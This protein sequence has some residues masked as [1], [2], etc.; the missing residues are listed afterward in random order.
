[1]ILVATLADALVFQ[2]WAAVFDVRTLDLSPLGLATRATV[3]AVVG[4]A[5]FELLDR[6][7]PREGRA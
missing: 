7:L 3:N 5:L 6:R 2:W 4:V 1:V